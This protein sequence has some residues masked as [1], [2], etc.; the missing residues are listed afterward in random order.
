[1]TIDKGKERYNGK[2]IAVLGLAKSGAA[3]ARVLKA[4]GANVLVNDM[5]PKSEC[6][7]AEELE[8]EGIR[9]ICGEHPANL[10]DETIDMVVKNPGI[11]YTSPPV[12]RALALGIPV[13]TE[14]EVAYHLSDAPIIGI[15][16]S[17]G[18]TTTTTLLGRIFEEANR[19][20][21]VAGNIGTPLSE[22]A[23]TVQA[24]QVLIAELSSFQLKGTQDFHPSIACLL[25]VYDAHLDYHKTKEDYVYSKSRLF[26]N[27]GAEDVAVLNY[28]NAICRGLEPSIRSTVLWFSSAGEVEQGSYIENGD[29]VFRRPQ[30]GPLSERMAD[31]A[32]VEKIIA[33]DDVALPGLHNLE[34]VL[35]AVCMARAAGIAPGTIRSVLSAFAGVEHRLEFVA[36]VDG[37]KYYNDSKAT[38]PEASSRAIMSF[39]APV[40]L[41]AGGLDR[42]ID[43]KEL[44]PLLKKHVKAMITYGQTAEKLLA[45]GQEAGI[46]N[47]KR[48]DT[49]TDAVAEAHLMAQSGDIVLLSPAC[50]SW[51]MYTS[52]EERGSMFKQ[53]V[54]KLKTSR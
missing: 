10:P 35:A 27:Q 32:P 15:T 3:V 6:P 41:I 17:N 33:V 38:N 47:C 13:V 1:M 48:V 49:V 42:G 29:V 14:V 24:D 7:A 16:G 52:F 43:F 36:D 9:V 11:P 26:A 20:P 51:D 12:Q 8:R 21:V 40:V 25:N 4:C 28:D 2:N 54:H 23:V 5:K 44:V 45:R 19:A 30:S 22:Q 18:K 31:A 46:N 37:V 50:A 34:N 53:S 39:T